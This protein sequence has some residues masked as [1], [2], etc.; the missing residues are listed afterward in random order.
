[1]INPHISKCLLLIALLVI[2]LMATPALAQSTI[3]IG[4]WNIQ[5]LGSPQCRPSNNPAQQAEEIADFVI[6]S[7]V[8][9]LGL[10]EITDDDNASATQTNRTLTH[11]MQIIQQKTGQEWRYGLFR[12]FQNGTGCK[13]RHIQL[14]GLA[15]NTTRARSVG[16]VRI[17]INSASAPNNITVWNRHPYAVKF[18]FGQNQT[19]VVLI[20]VHMK[21]NVGT[22]TA[23]VREWEARLLVQQLNFVRNHF[24]DNDIIILG[25]TNV[26]G[27]HETAITRLVGAGFSDLNGQDRST[28][29][30]NEAFDRIFVRLGQPEFTG[31]RQ[32]VFGRDYLNYTTEQF[33]Q[34]LSDH[35]LVKTS[36]SISTDDDDPQ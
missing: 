29:I 30:R 3:T 8:D 19:D 7:G 35:Y 17:P 12:K 15:W 33:L 26:L 4:A 31:S 10:S 14:V 9:V 28:T 34:R 6:A 16:S 2:A 21:S 11:A 18:Q 20:V 22:N 5:Y 25:D 27:A 32:E 13:A 36:I 23:L 24:K 1:M